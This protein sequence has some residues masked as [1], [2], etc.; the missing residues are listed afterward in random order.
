MT[1]TIKAV[2]DSPDGYVVRHYSDDTHPMIKYNGG[3]IE[4]NGEREDAEAF[5]K[6]I[7]KAAI[8]AMQIREMTVE[9][10]AYEIDAAIS[11]SGRNGEWGRD[12]A[13]ALAKLGCIRIVGEV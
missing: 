13:K 5:L 8:E 7:Y 2:A 6:A 9:E 12:V 1:D 4:I 10:V 11:E 3:Y